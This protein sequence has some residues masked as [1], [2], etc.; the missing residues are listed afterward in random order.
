MQLQNISFNGI[1]ADAIKKG[2]ILRKENNPKFE[3]EVL[4]TKITPEPTKEEI[5][6]GSDIPK[7][8][9]E[10]TFRWCNLTTPYKKYYK[11]NEIIDLDL[12]GWAKKQPK[13]GEKIWK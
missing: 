8:L 13:N 5:R 2:M 7:R 6:K 1:Q 12:V 3:F 9:K 10:I 4:D 11:L